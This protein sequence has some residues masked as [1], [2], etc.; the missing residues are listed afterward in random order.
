MLV[1]IK[2]NPVKLAVV[3]L[4]TAILNAVIVPPLATEIGISVL[5]YPKISVPAVRAYPVVGIY[6]FCPKILTTATFPPLTILP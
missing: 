5:T 6:P 2:D 3:P 4:F 1:S